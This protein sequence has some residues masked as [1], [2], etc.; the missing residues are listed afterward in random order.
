MFMLAALVI[1]FAY[2]GVAALFRRVRATRRPQPLEPVSIPSWHP[3]KL[4]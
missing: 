3:E 2:R 1:W 4:P